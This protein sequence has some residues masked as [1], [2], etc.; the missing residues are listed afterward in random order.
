MKSTNSP[1]VDVID[2]ST[3][4]TWLEG[5]P[6]TEPRVLVDV[7]DSHELLAGHIPGAIH[8]PLVGLSHS[9][10]ACIPD[11]HSSIV[12]YCAAGLRAQR[13]AEILQGLGYCRV[14]RV[15]TGFNQWKAQ[16]HP[17]AFTLVTQATSKLS[18]E[19][20]Q[21]YSRHLLL[22][23]IGEE[24]QVRLL[25]AKILI[26][27]VGGLGTPAALYLAAAGI[28]TLGLVDADVV[29]LSNLQRQILHTTS[30]LGMPKVDSA[31]QVLTDLNRDV[32]IIP[33]KT[34]IDRHNID[35]IFAQG[36]DVIIDGCDNFPTRYLI[37]DASHFHDIP[38]VHGSVS[39][40]EGRVAT[41]LPKIGPCYR[42]LY[43]EP[44]PAQLTASCDEAGVLG[45]LPG[46]I[47]VIQATEAIKLVLGLGEPLVGR[48]LTYDA[49]SMQFSKLSFVRH[50]DCELCG[51]CPTITSYIDY[52]EIC[53]TMRI[54]IRM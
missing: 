36:W 26:L 6:G 35:D 20:R 34:R 50:A 3:L 46:V 2:V 51:D 8:L 5:R 23:E 12:V 39:R 9:A 21:R 16:A 38:V 48:L 42:C 28:G 7:R 27:G 52:E 11:R 32:T 25:E 14:A 19:Q 24:Q 22:P 31:T 45:V 30:R 54:P 44:P 10:T 13:A 43:P 1:P 29:E 40:F 37:N 47:G 53:T 17:V 33:F 41:F 18:L 4:A 15:D 49:L